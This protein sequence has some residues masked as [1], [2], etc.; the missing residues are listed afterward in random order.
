M[1]LIHSFAPIAGPSPRVLILGTMPGKAS[2]A[3]NQYYAHP[4]NSFW[5]IMGEVFRFKPTLPYE[6]RVEILRSSGTAV[7]DVLQLCTRESSLDSD[8]DESSI[9]PNDFVGF[10]ASYPSIERLYFNGAK[11]AELYRKHVRSTLD[12]RWRSLEAVRLPST[13]PANAG[14][15]YCAKLLAWSSALGGER[16]ADPLGAGG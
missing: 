13:S 14:I 10:L 8:I 2:L 16:S 6:E 9:V 15:P 5:P 3:A 11:A 1:S 4:R 7:W 12:D